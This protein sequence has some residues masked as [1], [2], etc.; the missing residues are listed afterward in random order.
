MRITLSLP[1]FIN[2]NTKI[3]KKILWAKLP[4]FKLRPTVAS[5]QQAA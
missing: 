4:F 3:S 5:V 2:N 1:N